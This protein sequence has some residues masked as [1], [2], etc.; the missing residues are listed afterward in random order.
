MLSIPQCVDHVRMSAGLSAAFFYTRVLNLRDNI[1]IWF[2]NKQITER[3]ALICPLIAG[4][5]I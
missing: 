5:Y 1:E 3:F 4:E 2:T